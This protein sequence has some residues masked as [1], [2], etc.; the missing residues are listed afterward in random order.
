MK[1]AEYYSGF[2][3]ARMQVGQDMNPHLSTDP[4]YHEWDLGYRDGRGNTVR[5]S[6]SGGTGDTAMSKGSKVRLRT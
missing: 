5:V 4:K 6:C 1:T 3:A 2:H